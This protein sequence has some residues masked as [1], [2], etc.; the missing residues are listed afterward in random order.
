MCMN[1]ETNQTGIF[2]PTQ[3]QLS[4]AEEEQAR[5]RA[6]IEMETDRWKALHDELDITEATQQEKASAAVL[7]QVDTVPPTP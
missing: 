6:E 5:L 3:S 4:L 2:L 1:T 7:K